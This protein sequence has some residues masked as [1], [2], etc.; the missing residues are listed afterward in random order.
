MRRRPHPG[1]VATPPRAQRLI[2]AI[3]IAS[4]VALFTMWRGAGIRVADFAQI[5]YGARAMWSGV[6]PYAAIGPGRAYDWPFPFLYPLTA[7]LLVAPLAMLP[8]PTAAAVFVGLSFALFL[9]AIT[10]QGWKGLWTVLAMPFWYALTTAQWSPLF[11]AAALVAPLGFVFVAKPTIGFALW[12]YRPTLSAVLGGLAVLAL[13]FALQPGWLAE[14]RDAL[15]GTGH[16]VLPI[17]HGVG[18]LLLLAL[19]RWRRPEAR[20]LLALACLPQTSLPYELLPLFLV[21]QSGAEMA[22]LAVLSDVAFALWESARPFTLSSPMDVAS[23]SVVV[24]LVYVPCLVMILRRPN[25]GDPVP[26]IEHLVARLRFE[27]GRVRLAS[28]AHGS[29]RAEQREAER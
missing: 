3:T 4:V 19:L 8:L 29:S 9:Y 22:V 28:A 1:S 23:V 20:L 21:P 27:V 17:A 13:A 5:W 11:T 2:V 10:A 7:P 24:P 15:R 18:P 25:V 6:S 16:M 26:W 14:W 12:T